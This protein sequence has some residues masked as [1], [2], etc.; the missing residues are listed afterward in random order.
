MPGW[1]KTG[2][3]HDGAE[4]GLSLAPPPIGLSSENDT[5]VATSQSKALRRPCEPAAWVA[6]RL[7][8]LR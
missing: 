7:L 6:G 5:V 4:Y 3:E 1:I 8:W 2:G